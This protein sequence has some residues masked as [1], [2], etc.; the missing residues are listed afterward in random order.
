MFN[1]GVLATRVYDFANEK[2]IHYPTLNYWEPNTFSTGISLTVLVTKSKRMAYFKMLLLRTNGPGGS[3]KSLL[4]SYDL[5][6]GSN[7]QWNLEYNSA[8]GPMMANYWNGT[9]NYSNQ[10]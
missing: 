2:L 1:E 6:L 8:F 3:T 4:F 10:N 9:F 7:G 5:D